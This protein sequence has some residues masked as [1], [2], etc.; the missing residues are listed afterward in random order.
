MTGLRGRWAAGDETLGFWLSIPGVLGAE[1][2][3]RQPVDYVCV[4]TQHGAI[5]YADSVAM[6]Q[7]IDLAGGTPIVRVP[8]N[9]QGIIGKNVLGSGIEF[10][11]ELFV[12]PGG[13]VQGRREEIQVQMRQLGGPG[14]LGANKVAEDLSVPKWWKPTREMERYIKT[15]LEQE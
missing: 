5:D 4:D 2:A 11:L 6:I 8:W 12:S 1:L 13:Y 14:Y 10:N 3:A 15:Y 9:E 7:A